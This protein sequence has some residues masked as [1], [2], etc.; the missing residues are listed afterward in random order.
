MAPSYFFVSLLVHF[1]VV[2]YAVS[3]RVLFHSKRYR[4][5]NEAGLILLFIH[6][7]SHRKVATNERESFGIAAEARPV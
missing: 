7:I 4:S 6:K 2:C 3:L 5:E 1:R